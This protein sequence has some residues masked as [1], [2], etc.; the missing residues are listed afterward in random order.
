MT[1]SFLL[2]GFPISSPRGFLGWSNAL[3]LD[4]AGVRIVVDTGGP[5]DRGTLMRRM[6]EVGLDPSSVA[7]L[8]LTH[9]HFDHCLNL[10][11]F[12]AATIVLS[13]AEHA[14]VATG[15]YRRAGDTGIPPYV[16][17]LLEGRTL[18]F[19]ED[20]LPVIAGVRVVATPGH[21]PGSLSVVYA[22]GGRHTVACADL[23]KNG[24]D[25]LSGPLSAQAKASLARVLLLGSR[26]IPG[27][28]RPFVVEGAGIRYEGARE[29]ELH[30]VRDPA[31][32]PTT[33][34]WSFD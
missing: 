8:I 14:Y 1:E 15:A 31:R 22:V 12:P 24:W 21:T 26:V 3:L 23:V 29:V 19:V 13:R 16:L 20:E 6:Q 9:L 11:L 32:G 30:V 17:S 7:F 10:D 2:Q 18:R 33:T 5:G 28:D 25:F 4:D 34:R 27:H